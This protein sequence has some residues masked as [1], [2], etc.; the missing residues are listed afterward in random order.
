[1]TSDDPNPPKSDP[2]TIKPWQ[3]WSLLLFVGIFA[4]GVRY[5]YVTHAQVFQP[6]N[7]PNVR[8]DAAEYYHYAFNLAEHGVFSKALPGTRPL[9][10]DSF[11][12]PGYPVFLAGWMK[13]FPQW[14]N[15]YAA[16]LMSQA[17]LSALTVVLTLALAR[18]WM[19]FGWLA[20][21]GVLMAAW[22]HSVAMSS[23]LLSE[24]LFGFL[25]ALGL[26]LLRTAVD[27]QRTSWAAASGIGFSLAALTNAV[28]IPL[29]PL[30]AFYLFVRKKASAKLCA[31][32][33]IAALA[34]LTPWM[35]RN[36]LMPAEAGNSSSS[37]RALLNLVQ[38]SW[39]SLHSAYQASMKHD[40]NGSRIMAAIEHESA[41]MKQSLTAGLKMMG[42]RMADNPGRYV[43]WYL[44]KPA[45]LWAWDIRIGQGD[46]YVYPTR[47]SP[48]KTNM[49]WRSVSALCRS[50]NPWLFVLA[51]LGGLVPFLPRQMTPPDRTAAALTLIFIT[52][53]YSVLQAEPRYSVPFRGLEIVL[54]VF[55]TFRLSEWTRA[56]KERYRGMSAVS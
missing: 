21:A 36:A 28:L 14:D 18:R 47:N 24:T 49:V 40:A 56:F 45:L 6:V 26:L 20:G 9:M 34:V 13:V 17:L 55:A 29:A 3:W 33:A 2:V 31:T 50:L 8:A 39:P 46:V 4:F 35:M 42:H 43:W 19:S 5:Y 54:A 15:W 32:L 23:Y 30:L 38:G 1:M 16:V 48:F 22:P 7:Q 53:V 25:A 10:G 37:G 41:V 12:D 44:S 52:L 27:R 51:I 11:R